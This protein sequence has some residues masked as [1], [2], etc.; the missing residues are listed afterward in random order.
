[1]GLET[2][3]VLNQ[4]GQKMIRANIIA[5]LDPI[6]RLAKRATFITIKQGFKWKPHTEGKISPGRVLM[7]KFGWKLGPFFDKDKL[8]TREL[9][10]KEAGQLLDL[11]S[12]WY[13][14][15]AEIVCKWNTSLPPI[16][17]LAEVGISGAQWIHDDVPSLHY[18][19][20]DLSRERVPWMSTLNIVKDPFEQVERLAFF[21]W[22]WEPGQT[23]NVSMATKADKA[24]VDLSL[25]AV[26]GMDPEME[27]HRNVL[28][29]F[30]LRC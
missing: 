6:A 29:T 30:F 12:E 22:V 8:S 5:G 13:Q 4:G 10:M 23:A 3:L 19:Y 1:V 15:I 20:R 7:E 14:D 28:R 21:G 2:L 18:A 9:T 25:W 27:Q 16:R 17:L 24:Q 11:R 26:G